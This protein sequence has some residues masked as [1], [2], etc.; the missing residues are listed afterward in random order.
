MD[1]RSDCVPQGD[2]G[3]PVIAFGTGCSRSL[4]RS[5]GD[6]EN[7]VTGLHRSLSVRLQQSVARPMMTNL[8]VYGI[9]V[10]TFQEDASRP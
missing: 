9:A 4:R 2:G 6:D 1:I 10:A 7:I 3:R 8:P 5:R